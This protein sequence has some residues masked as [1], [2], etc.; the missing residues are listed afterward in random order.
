MSTSS[1]STIITVPLV[2]AKVLGVR[3]GTPIPTQVKIICHL[4]EG[5]RLEFIDGSSAEE[6]AKLFPELVLQ[7]RLELLRTLKKR[8]GITTSFHKRNTQL[9]APIHIMEPPPRFI[10]EVKVVENVLPLA[11]PKV[12]SVIP[13]I[14]GAVSL[15]ITRSVTPLPIAQPVVPLPIAKPVETLPIAKPIEYAAKRDFGA[16][17]M[18]TTGHFSA[19][20]H[21]VD[22]P[23]A[24][25]TTSAPPTA[26]VFA[27]YEKTPKRLAALRAARARREQ[28]SDLTPSS[29]V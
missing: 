24:K 22:P 14:V 12:I 25:V 29:G 15:P 19:F 13:A 7:A 17:F 10:R 21:L 20:D 18:S 26:S 27:S 11:L 23:E 8:E 9:L 5:Y 28:A 16:E 4:T 1:L 6:V 3:F 2:R